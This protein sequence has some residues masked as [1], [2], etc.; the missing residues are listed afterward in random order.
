MTPDK[1]KLSRAN[2]ALFTAAYLAIGVAVLFDLLAL[3]GVIHR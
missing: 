2:V 1:P 3:F